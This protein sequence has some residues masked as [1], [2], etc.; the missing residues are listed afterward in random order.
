MATTTKVKSSNF[1]SDITNSF[2][3]FSMQN[4]TEMYLCKEIKDTAKT[5]KGKVK[6]LKDLL[7]KKAVK[8]GS[9]DAEIE[10][11]MMDVKIKS[12]DI[13]DWLMAKEMTKSSGSDAIYETKPKESSD[14][15]KSALKN[16]YQTFMSYAKTTYKKIRAT[17]DHGKRKI[18]EGP[19]RMT[20]EKFCKVGQCI[21]AALIPQWNMPTLSKMDMDTLSVQI[22]NHIVI[23]EEGIQQN[24]AYGSLRYQVKG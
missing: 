23:D 5:A 8:G 2:L 24:A 17:A 13:A 6:S 4:P 18:I 15:I 7:R 19:V 14:I 1:A 21:M 12:E 10:A 16:L 9:I 3:F 11:A 20:T 22:A